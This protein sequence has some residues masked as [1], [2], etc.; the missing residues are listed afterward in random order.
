[1]LKTQDELLAFLNHNKIAYKNQEHPAV[2]TVEEAA[3]HS[4]GIDGAQCK[5]LFL[6]D[7]KKNCFLIVTISDK[8]IVIKDIA[9][10]IGAKSLSF[11][12]PDLLLDV[13]GVTP[14]AVTPFA[15][16]NSSGK[17]LTVIFDQE[18]M[19]VEL[20]NFHPLV[21]TATTTISS[22]DIVKFTEL[23]E[24]KYEIVML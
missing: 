17:P 13:L 14:G 8:P 1:M 19:D 2:Y 20:L 12:K 3:F 22:K 10:K 5:N 18:M 15:S 9:R 23:I 24:I 4:K 6:K 7:K 11:G 16:I 21:N